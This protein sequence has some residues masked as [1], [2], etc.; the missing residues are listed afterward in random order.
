MRSNQTAVCSPFMLSGIVLLSVDNTLYSYNFD[1]FRVRPQISPEEK[2]LFGKERADLNAKRNY[3]GWKK[4]LRP[5]P[6]CCRKHQG[7]EKT[8]IAVIAFR[9]GS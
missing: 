2:A 6:F 8:M 1:P 9:Y 7:Y 3:S 4:F 5:Q